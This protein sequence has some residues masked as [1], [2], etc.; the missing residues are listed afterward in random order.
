MAWSSKQLASALGVTSRRINQLVVDGIVTRPGKAGFDP[1]T[2]VQ[3]YLAF[4]DRRVASIPLKDAR[5]RKLSADAALSEL[6]LEV[7]RGRFVAVD[8]VKKAAFVTAHRVLDSILNIPD[9]VAP[10]LAAEMDAGKVHAVLMYELRQ[11][12]E[13]LAG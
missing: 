1:E 2:A 13:H 5:E 11:A 9:R 6:K 10:I 12:L 4:V 3:Q 7:E 8:D